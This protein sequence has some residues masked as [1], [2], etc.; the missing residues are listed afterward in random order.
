MTLFSR[1]LPGGQRLVVT[2][3]GPLAWDGRRPIF[4]SA[5][6]RYLVAV[7][8]VCE[9]LCAVFDTDSSELVPCDLG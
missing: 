5:P 8:A 3:A 4:L 9:G 2:P 1:R 7:A 6:G